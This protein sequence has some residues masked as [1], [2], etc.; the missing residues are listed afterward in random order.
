M[1]WWQGYFGELYLRLFDGMLTPAHTAREVAGVMMLL[2]QPH[3]SRL[4]DLGCGQGRHA[5]P[6]ARAGYEV[7]GADRS[8]YLLEHAQQRADRLGMPVSWVQ[9]DMRA[10]PWRGQFD[11]C[12]NL[13][14][15]FGYFE[16]D[17]ENEQVLHEVCRVLKPGGKFLLDIA[18]RDYYLMNLWPRAWR[19][20]GEALIL[21][22]TE[23]DPLTGRFETRF[24]VLEGGRSESLAH[25]VRYYT[26]PELRTM[27]ARAGL[28]LLDFYGDFEGGAFGVQ[29]RRLIAVAQKQ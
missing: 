7:T 27:L 20:Q 25:S 21:E 4:L 12:I 8:A 22:E 13:F 23:F 24:T 16:D 10:L 14:N 5:V 9:A 26:A 15:S 29:S 1:A 19:R 28:S 17:A 3:G 18:N 11:A 6:L 2:D